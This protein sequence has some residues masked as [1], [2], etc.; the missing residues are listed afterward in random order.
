MSD[1]STID[2]LLQDF[3][4]GAFPAAPWKSPKTGKPCTGAASDMRIWKGSFPDRGFRL[5]SGFYV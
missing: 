1:F 2:R 5:P 3:V 4:D